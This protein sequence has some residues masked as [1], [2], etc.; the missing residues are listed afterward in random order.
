VPFA[1][2]CINKILQLANC[3]GIGDESF[4]QYRDL[5]AGFMIV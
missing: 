1:V 5:V 3:I 2:F 4:I